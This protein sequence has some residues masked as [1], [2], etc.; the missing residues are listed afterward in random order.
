MIQD[1]GTNHVQANCALVRLSRFGQTSPR[2]AGIVTLTVSHMT[3][4]NPQD[5]PGDPNNPPGGQ[6]PPPPPPQGGYPAPG[7]GAPMQ[8]MQPMQPPPGSAAAHDET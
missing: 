6:Y 2:R 8:P 3:N 7:Y 5:Y 1:G 4:P